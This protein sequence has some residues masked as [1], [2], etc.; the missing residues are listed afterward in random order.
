LERGMRASLDWA[1]R[2][3]T[4]ALPAELGLIAAVGASVLLNGVAPSLAALRWVVCAAVALKLILERALRWP[5]HPA[6]VALVVAQ[7]PPYGAFAAW[8]LLAIA[9]VL[10]LLFNQGFE[11]PP[12]FTG[13]FGVAYVDAQLQIAGSEPVLVRALYPVDPALLLKSRAGASYY[14]EQARSV[15]AAM[16]QIGSPP[17]LNFLPFL[18]DHLLLLRTS[19]IKGGSKAPIAVSRAPVLVWSHGL[20]STREQYLGIVGELA[21]RGLIVL[22][23]E[24]TD[25]SAALARFPDGGSIPYSHAEEELEKISDGAYVRARRLQLEL[26]ASELVCALDAAHAL[27]GE[28]GINLRPGPRD[29]GG[30]KD[31]C[32]TLWGKIDS[33]RIIVGG[34]SMGG[35]S[36]VTAALRARKAVSACMLFDPATDWCPDEPARV[37]LVGEPAAEVKTTADAPG[38]ASALPSLRSLAQTPT[39]A[40]YTDEWRKSGFGIPRHVRAHME[41]GGFGAGSEFAY[42]QGT[43]HVGVSDVPTMLP[44]ALSRSLKFLD[45]ASAE[46]NILRLRAR[47]ISFLERI[48]F[49]ATHAHCGPAKAKA[50]REGDEQ[51]LI[52]HLVVPMVRP[53]P[54]ASSPWSPASVPSGLRSLAESP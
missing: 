41:A 1:H 30:A 38:Y 31:L 53:P 2:P 8:P 34:H 23:V 50:I 33:E 27:S 29:T 14:S 10:C 22:C 28:I 42:V 36:A 39:L 16:M 47:V 20:T 43:T 32:T 5:F 49:M 11:G 40:I 15:T 25:G 26:R 17:P 48:E 21:S 35:A 12:D 7:L 13:P 6:V 54:R 9:A 51:L 52:E 44:G 24:H 46:Q 19:L 37:A 18:M 3:V 4:A 45:G